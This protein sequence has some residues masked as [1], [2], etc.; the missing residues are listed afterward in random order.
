MMKMAFLVE[1]FMIKQ[2]AQRL[3]FI[4]QQVIS[5]HLM[6]IISLLMTVQFVHLQVVNIYQQV[7]RQVAVIRNIMLVMKAMAIIS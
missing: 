6:V 7:Q 5:S 3:A 1:S 2:V 4:V